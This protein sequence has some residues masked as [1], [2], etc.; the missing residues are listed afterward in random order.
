MG[1][2]DESFGNFSEE[3]K[4]AIVNMTDVVDIDES[5][6]LKMQDKFV[7]MFSECYGGALSNVFIDKLKM[8]AA[9]VYFTIQ[10]TAALPLIVEK[11]IEHHLN[12]LKYDDEIIWECKE[13]ECFGAGFCF[14]PLDDLKYK[15]KV[16]PEGCVL[17]E[18]NVSDC[19]RGNPEWVW[20]VND[21]LC[22]ECRAQEVSK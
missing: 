8:S 15:Q 13:G 11:M 14:I 21:G 18:C 10:T 20:S 3:L 7:K 9:S 16:C 2:T 6:R 17:M 5:L 4:E 1:F 12:Y 19:K 22:I